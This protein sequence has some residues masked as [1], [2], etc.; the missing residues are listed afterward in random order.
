MAEK[1]NLGEDFH[2]IHRY[3]KTNNKYTKHHNQNKES[4]YLMYWNAN[5]LHGWAMYWKLPTDNF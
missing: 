3:A 5:N 2:E 4:S 1:Q